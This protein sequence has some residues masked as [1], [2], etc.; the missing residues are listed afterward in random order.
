MAFGVA[1]ISAAFMISLYLGGQYLLELDRQNNDIPIGNITGLGREQYK[2]GM[3][4]NNE[5]HKIAQIVK[6]KAAV[7]Y[8]Y[9]SIPT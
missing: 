6:A 2:Y 5:Y 1:L 7:Y 8:N 9:L 4:D 3:F